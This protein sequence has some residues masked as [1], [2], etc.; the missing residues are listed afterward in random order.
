MLGDEEMEPA[1]SVSPEEELILLRNEGKIIEDQY[2]DLLGA[3]RTRPVGNV[4][5]AIASD[6]PASGAKTGK[7]AFL[8][9]LV[10]V[11]L[12]FA[13]FLAVEI[14]GHGVD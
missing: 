7:I 12:P 8:L 6:K 2:N 1:S 14:H 11:T 5:F 9:M 3:M 4:V 13:C 10:G